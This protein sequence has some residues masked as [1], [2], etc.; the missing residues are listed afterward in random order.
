MTERFH[1]LVDLDGTITDPR[2]GIVGSLQAALGRVGAPVPSVAELLWVIG[3]PMRTA[4]PRLGVPPHRIE[5]AIG[6]YREAYAAGAMYDAPVYPGM[7]EALDA[8]AASGLRLL[9]ATSKPHHFARPILAHFGL[10]A[11]FAGMYGAELDGRNDDKGD[12]LADII[13]REGVDPRRA[14]MVGDR[15]FDVLAAARHGIP[16]IGALWGYG[17]AEELTAAGAAHLCASPLHLPAAV[18]AIRERARVAA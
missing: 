13:A 7:P 3:P 11:K 5:E 4:L 16:C 10:T 15:R 12:L 2:P 6:H 1:V 14:I 17:G 18:A 9:V 8:L